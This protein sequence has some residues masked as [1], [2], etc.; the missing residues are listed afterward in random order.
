MVAEATPYC[1]NSVVTQDIIMI[2]G[3]FV[4]GCSRACGACREMVLVDRWG[5][6]LA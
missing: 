2:H 1:N 6:A 4:S 5:K 3:S